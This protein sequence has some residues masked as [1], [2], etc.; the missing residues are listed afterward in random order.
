[1]DIFG[2]KA[3]PFTSR[4]MDHLNQIDP[5]FQVIPYQGG[6]SVKASEYQGSLSELLYYQSAT[7]VDDIATSATKIRI[8][9]KSSSLGSEFLASSQGQ[10]DTW[11]R[12]ENE[13]L[14]NVDIQNSNNNVLLLTVTR[15][16]NNTI[17][18]SHTSGCTVTSPLYEVSPKQTKDF[19][20]ISYFVPVF[21][22]RGTTIAKALNNYRQQTGSNGIWIDIVLGQLNARTMDGRRRFMLWN[23]T[24]NSPFNNTDYIQYT[25]TTIAS[26]KEKYK[27]QFGEY[28]IIYGNNALFSTQWNE[29][30]K[31]FLMVPGFIGQPVIN[32]MCQENSWGHMMS[33]DDFKEGN[34][35]ESSSIFIRG[36][37]D[38]FL[39]WFIADKWV[40]NCQGVAILSQKGLPNQPMSINAG[41]K[42]K[43]FASDLSDSICY[44]FNKFAYVSYLFC[45]HVNNE[46]VTS[47]R[48]GFS[49]LRVR[50]G[51]TQVVIE[52]FFYYPIGTPIEEQRY[53][54][55]A[56]YQFKDNNIF[57]RR[58]SNGIIVINS[59]KTAMS[60]AIKIFDI[61]DQNEVRFR[62]R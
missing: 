5:S 14:K 50:N 7:L 61:Y 43:W 60:S 52:D 2:I 37:N 22:E 25:K 57:V 31:A 28:P 20:E 19:K 47:T 55:F 1:M 40:S 24:T 29:G 26:I 62:I 49:P 17:T 21:G 27:Q 34:N 4:L 41:F 15:G 11:I 9:G 51:I 35:T 45:I 54:K 30:A 32:G 10:Y 53:D 18:A 23:Y 46:G 56:N 36:Q 44:A 16:Y 12:I 33:G 13:L 38:H 39:Q 42:K 8:E 6:W 58:F 3:L 59:F 48:M